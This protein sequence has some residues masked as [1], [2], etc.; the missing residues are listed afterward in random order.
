MTCQEIGFVQAYLDGELTREER[1]SFAQHLE[2]CPSCQRLVNEMKQLDN[3]TRI[4]I[5]ESYYGEPSP[6][7][8]DT[9]AA[10]E[11]FQMHVSQGQSAQ[12]AALAATKKKEWSWNT[13]KKTYKNW[14]VGTSAAA[15]L[16]GTFTIPQVQAVASDIL[17]IFR[18]NQVEFI[19]LTEEDMRDV[20]DWFQSSSADEKEI[21]GLGKVWTDEKK[22]SEPRHF[23]TAA[24]VKNAGFTVPALP[25]GYDANSFQISPSRTVYI[26]LDTEKANKL[27]R[28]FKA[29]T[30]FDEK[31]NGKEFSL[32]IPQSVRIELKAKEQADAAA[33]VFNYEV[34]DAP[35]ITAPKDVD[36]EQLRET[37]LSLP[38]IPDNVKRQLGDIKDWQHTLPIPYVENKERDLKEVKL[39]GTVGMLF[40]SEK[41][42]S[43]LWQKDGKLHMLDMSGETIDTERLIDLANNL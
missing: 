4:A 33:L 6:G 8:I 39:K 22:D 15:V 36:L 9:Q 21:K 40:Q 27:L 13:M 3:W 19:K 1:K 42:A 32:T 38:F 37:V 30:Q 14:I 12:R 28:Q 43:L 31:L 20:Q 18:V 5:E 25:A 26:Q 10:W 24:Q 41:Y 34:V 35:E 2:F 29:D 11:R 16:L 23:A 17:S 7:T